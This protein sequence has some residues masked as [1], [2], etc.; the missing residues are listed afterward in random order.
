MGE[1]IYEADS[2]AANGPGEGRGRRFRLRRR[3]ASLIT[4][5]TRS[6]AQNR[7]HRERVY[8]SIQ[9]ARVPLLLLC[10]LSVFL[11]HNWWLSAILFIISVPLPAV[12]VIIANEKGEKRDPRS[13]NVYK[14]AVMREL[15]E[16]EQLEAR[17]RRELT[18]P[19]P[20][21]QAPPRIIDNE[22]DHPDGPSPGTEP[23]PSGGNG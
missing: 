8:F 9:L 13:R 17:A 6:A 15:A 11:W 22:E 19:D 5:A 3:R 2:G 12:A 4:T 7:L 21:P 10:G 1:E 14:P 23:D 18:E 20:D 16:Q